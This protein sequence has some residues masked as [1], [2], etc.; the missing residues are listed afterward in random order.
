MIFPLGN[1]RTKDVAFSPHRLG[2]SRRFAGRMVRATGGSFTN[3]ELT[4]RGGSVK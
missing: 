2:S 1:Q 3:T 4:D